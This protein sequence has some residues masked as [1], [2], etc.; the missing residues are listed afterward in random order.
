MGISEKSIK[1]N[2]KTYATIFNIKAP[3]LDHDPV[4]KIQLNHPFRTWGVL[5]DAKYPRGVLVGNTM[6]RGIE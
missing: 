6:P 2:A 5:V 3:L 4:L 1:L